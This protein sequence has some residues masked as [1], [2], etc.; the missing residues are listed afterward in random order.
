[1]AAYYRRQ[2]NYFAGKMA[3][4]VI[5]SVQL[6]EQQTFTATTCRDLT[7]CRECMFRPEK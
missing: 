1:M 2:G 7:F 5:K 3:L 4:T 6:N